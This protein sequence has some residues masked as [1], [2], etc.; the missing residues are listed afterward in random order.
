MDYT[1]VIPC[2]IWLDIIDLLDYENNK[3]NLYLTNIRFFSM[4]Q[5]SKTKCDIMSHISRTHSLQVLK[6]IHQLKNTTNVNIPFIQ[7]IGSNTSLLVACQCG[8]LSMVKYFIKCGAN[9]RFDTDKPVRL[10]AA[11]GHYPVVKYLVEKGAD[12]LSRKNYALRHAAQNGHLDMMRYLIEKGANPTACDYQAILLACENKHY[13]V[14][15]YLLELNPEILKKKY[16]LLKAAFIGGS[17]EI[18]DYLNKCDPLGT[19]TVAEQR[20]FHHVRSFR[21]QA[22]HVELGVRRR[23]EAGDRDRL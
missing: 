15:Q 10:A 21:R 3:Y 8:N 14:F 9:F 22:I 13:H 18:V 20:L 7:N 5:Y 2:E 17:V 19:D 6:Y 23:G 1:S 4:L 11:N 12:V 16:L